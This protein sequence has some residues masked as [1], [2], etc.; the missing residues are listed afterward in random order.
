MVLGEAPLCNFRIYDGGGSDLIGVLTSE[1]NQNLADVISESYGWN[2]DAATA[3]SAHNQHLSMSAQGITYMAATGDSGATLAA[4]SYPDYDP[5][6][7]MVGGT[8]PTTDG[9]GKRTSDV[10]PSSGG[11]GWRA[12]TVS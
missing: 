4:Y 6:V 10:A 1:V 9:V 3:T 5:E 8:V 2:L 12:A 7:L 11:S